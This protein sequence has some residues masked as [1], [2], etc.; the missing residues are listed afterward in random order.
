MEY[1]RVVEC[2]NG[3]F[4]E[5]LATLDLVERESQLLIDADPGTPPLIPRAPDNPLFDEQDVFTFEE[6]TQKYAHVTSF[7]SGMATYE[8]ALGRWKTKQKRSNTLRAQVAKDYF[9]G[10]L[11]LENADPTRF[12]SLS[13]SGGKGLLC[14]LFQICHQCRRRS[15]HPKRSCPRQCEFVQQSWRRRKQDK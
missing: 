2:G 3:T 7:L 9:L 1:V 12:G 4:G 15:S 5:D 13:A 11:F 10:M 6:V 8:E 14:R